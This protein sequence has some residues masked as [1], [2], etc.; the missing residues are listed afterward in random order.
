MAQTLTRLL[1]HVVF[2]T[3]DREPL[4]TP[5][6]ET[7]LYMYL[8]GIARNLQSPI[9]SIGGMP[10]HVHMLVV[11]SKNLALASLV[12]NLKQD[13]SKWIKSKGAAFGR[14]AWQAGYGAFSVG[15]SQRSDVEAYINR[16][17][18]HHARMSFQDEL[19]IIL[20]RYNIEFDER[21]LWS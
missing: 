4:V 18:Q 8:C 13:S 17:K 10:D 7:E 20:A 2:S 14:F 5:D 1:V 19:R 9:V 11:L 3:K 16:Q 21:Y 15:E 6:I 12:Q